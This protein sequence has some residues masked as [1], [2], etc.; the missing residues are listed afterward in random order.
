VGCDPYHSIASPARPM[1][2]IRKETTITEEEKRSSMICP[3]VSDIVSRNK[4]ANVHN[5]VIPNL[6]QFIDELWITFIPSA[7]HPFIH[8]LE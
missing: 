7:L 1:L 3:F 4:V 2:Q 5:Q 6:V 8:D